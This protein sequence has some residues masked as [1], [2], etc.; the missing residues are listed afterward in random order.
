MRIILETT[1]NTSII[2]FEY[3]Q[4]MLGVIHKWLGN[5]E[6]HNKISLYSFS[7]FFGG[8]M[9]DKQGFTFT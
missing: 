6:I 1:S 4:K 9:I 2:P 5:N 7:W 3:Q 8:T